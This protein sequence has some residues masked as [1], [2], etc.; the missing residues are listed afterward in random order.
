MAP[1]GRARTTLANMSVESSLA[2]LLATIYILLGSLTMI[3]LSG[4]M[5]IVPKPG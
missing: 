1:D 5:L 2:H 4:S 3:V